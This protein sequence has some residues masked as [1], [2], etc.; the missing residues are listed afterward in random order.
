[1]TRKLFILILFVAFTFVLTTGTYAQVIFGTYSGK[2]HIAQINRG[3]VNYSCE[4]DVG[5]C[6]SICV[7]LNEF[8]YDNYIYVTLS[9]VMHID[10]FNK[11]WARGVPFTAI[12]NPEYGRKGISE[13]E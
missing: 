9:G 1:M 8:W 5:D 2:G 3:Q 4:E 11:Y 13:E 7:V 12:M 10:G 6:L